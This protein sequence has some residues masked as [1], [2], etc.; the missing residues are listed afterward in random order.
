MAAWHDFVKKIRA[1]K[2]ISYKEALKVASPLWKAQKNGGKIAKKVSF[3][4]EAEVKPAKKKKRARKKSKK[5]VPQ[6][7][8]D[9]DFPKVKQSKKRKKIAKTE[10]V[11]L[12]NL[13]GSLLPLDKTTR[14][15]RA[16]KRKTVMYA[17]D[18]QNIAKQLRV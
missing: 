2:G 3:K 9:V 6:P 14:K 4:D 5:V 17:Q 1:E 11:K 18:A 10:A 12:T 16:R 7:S 13:G 8:E 15:R